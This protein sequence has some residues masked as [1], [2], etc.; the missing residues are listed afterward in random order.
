[1][2]EASMRA[3]PG[4]AVL[5]VMALGACDIDVTNLADGEA[6]V[7][8]MG[9]TGGIAGVDYTFELQDD[10]AIVG[11]RCENACD[12]Q[13]GDTLG[14]LTPA[15][16]D[17]V[18]DGVVASGL[19][20]AGRP[21]DFGTECCDQFAYRVIYTSGPV[22]RSFTGSSEA[23]PEPLRKLVRTLHLLYL[24]TPPV[25]VAQSTGLEGFSLD[26]LAILDARV[27]AGTLEVDVTYGGGCAYHDLD[28][29]VYTGWMESNPVQVGVAVTHDDHG[30]M[31]DAL[32]Q[33]TLRFDLEPLREAY[34]DAYGPG[35]ATLILRLEP[36][37]G[38]PGG[39]PQ[40]LTYSF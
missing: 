3:I 12:F 27:D 19:P 6:M 4:L 13:P 11:I 24:D 32:V 1:M 26:P 2:E 34:V 22:V 23:L 30:D 20:D 21:V 35:N 36:G 38:A 37:A 31:C 10:G 40:A 16:R 18:Q 8:R 5:A 28:A 14:R 33:R 25:I 29:V 17:A 15:Q 9:V 39:A 7:V